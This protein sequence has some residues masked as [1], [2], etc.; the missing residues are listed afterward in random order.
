MEEESKIK[1][2]NISSKYDS[3]I[4]ESAMKS[5]EDFSYNLR[6]IARQEFGELNE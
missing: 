3:E 4:E 5:K 1:R 6:V 2:S